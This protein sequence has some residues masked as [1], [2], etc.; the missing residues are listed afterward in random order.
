M[1]KGTHSKP[2]FW[3]SKSQHKKKKKKDIL[4]SIPVILEKKRLSIVNR[5]FNVLTNCMKIMDENMYVSTVVN[6]GKKEDQE[7][8]KPFVS[9]TSG[10]CPQ[11]RTYKLSS[12]SFWR[13]AVLFPHSPLS[14]LCISLWLN[15]KP[16]FSVS[17]VFTIKLISLLGL[18]WWY[19]VSML[20]MQNVYCTGT[21][22][23]VMKAMP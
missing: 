7:A 5:Y 12:C 9:L 16:L 2:N 6:M 11:H 19:K 17:E 18:R 4:H 23:H 20:R 3:P 1:H 10:K 21:L 22:Q 14:F 13:S 8:I 15:T